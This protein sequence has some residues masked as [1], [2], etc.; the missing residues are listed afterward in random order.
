MNELCPPCLLDELIAEYC[1]A[2]QNE[3]PATAETQRR[4][5]DALNTMLQLLGDRN[6]SEYSQKDLLALK[7]KLYRWPANANKLTELRDKT[8]EE[9]LRMKV[10]R[11]LDKRTVDKK[12]ME[13]II[14]VF[15]YAF[16]QK[17]IDRDITQ[18]VVVSRTVAEKRANKHKPYD[19]VDLKKIFEL[20]PVH[21]DRPY[22]AWLPLIAAYS[23]ARPGELCR[24]RVAD[25]NVTHRIPFMRITEEDDNGNIIKN[26]RGE[27]SLRLVPLH[28]VLVEMGLLQFISRRRD[29]G[30]QLLFELHR[31][32]SNEAVPLTGQYY[33]QSYEAFNRKFITNDLRKGFH[34]FRYS[35]H[36]ALQQTNVPPEM[37]YAITGQIP[38]YEDD[39]TAT[40]DRRLAN[41]YKA[42]VRLEFPGIDLVALKGKLSIVL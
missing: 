10:G 15:S 38:Q 32:G 12:Y 28:P 31:K 24:L 13:K 37:C 17:M 5:R 21:A 11:P 39:Q 35:V 19:A 33:A 30:K 22:L 29:Q 41:K 18:N 2:L 16:R 8:A 36:R 6:I 42:L 7:M 4:Y 27:E 23:G 9:I 14:A 26:A 20:L 34:S 40:E 3:R 1:T 25:I